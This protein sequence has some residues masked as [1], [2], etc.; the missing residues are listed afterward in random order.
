MTLA[1]VIVAHNEPEWVKQLTFGGVPVAVDVRHRPDLIALCDDGASLWIERKTSEDFLGALKDE[2][3]L[4]LQCAALSQERTKNGVWPYLIITGHLW[5]T[6]DG[7]TETE[8]GRTGWNWAA[9]QGALLAVQEMGVFVAY[10]ANDADFEAAVIRLSKRTHKAENL[11]L[12]ARPPAILPREYAV[13]DDLGIGPD[14][15]KVLLNHCGTLEVALMALVDDG[16]ELPKI[17]KADRTKVRAALYAN[18]H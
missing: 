2:G 17:T 3:N 12:P 10:A 15:A 14:R 4:F 6:S 13:L 16:T 8:R 18:N 9:V 11:I 5:P 7:M 1:A